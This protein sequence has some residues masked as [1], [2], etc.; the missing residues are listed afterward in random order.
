[1]KYGM[2]YNKLIENGFTKLAVVSTAGSN[3]ILGK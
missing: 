2:C 3:A 1:M